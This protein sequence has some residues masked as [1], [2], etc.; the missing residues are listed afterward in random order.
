MARMH[1]LLRRLHVGDVRGWNVS[2]PVNANGIQF[3]SETIFPPSAHF[4][5][6]HDTRS[7]NWGSCTSTTTAACVAGENA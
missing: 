4:R 1:E 2:E 7:E 3:V 6:T 5:G